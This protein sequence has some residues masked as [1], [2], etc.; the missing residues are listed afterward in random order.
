MSM[1]TVS[2]SRRLNAIQKKGRAQALPPILLTLARHQNLRRIWPI[3]CADHGL[4][5]H[6]RKRA[7]LLALLLTVKLLLI[8]PGSELLLMLPCGR[9]LPIGGLLL[10]LSAAGPLPNRHP[11]RTN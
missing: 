3:G 2:R 4:R 5:L 10:S 9:L 11:I 7:L 8:L 1:P 6:R